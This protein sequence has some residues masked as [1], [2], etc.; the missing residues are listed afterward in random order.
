MAASTRVCGRPS[1]L[2]VKNGERLTVTEVYGREALFWPRLAATFHL[3]G[4]LFIRETVS[5]RT[6]DEFSLFL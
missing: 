5:R 3:P 2:A 1:R 6:H 4:N